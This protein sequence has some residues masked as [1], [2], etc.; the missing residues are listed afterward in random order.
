[1]VCTAQRSKCYLIARPDHLVIEN[2]PAVVHG[3][4][5]D[6]GMIDA[7][8]EFSEHAAAFMAFF[9]KERDIGVGDGQEDR[10]Q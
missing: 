7:P 2:V 1:M 10:L 5:R 6:E 8:L 9:L 3:E 4:D